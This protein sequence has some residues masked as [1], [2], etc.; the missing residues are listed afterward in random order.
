[1]TAPQVAA[2]RPWVTRTLLGVNVL[3]FV[4]M[5]V[6]G[7]SFE[8]AEQ[9]VRW[10]ADFGPLTLHGEWWRLATAMFLHFGFLHLAFNMWAL[11]QVGSVAERLFGP[12]AFLALYV[13]SGLGGSVM[14]VWWHPLVVGGGASGAIFG[15]A[16]GLIAA[17]LL[18][19]ASDGV[20]ALERVLPSLI[21][22]VLYNLLFG[23]RTPGID[24][25]AHM[26]GLLVG[27]LFGAVLAQW[28]GISRAWVTLDFALALT[29]GA[30]AAARVR[31]PV[32]VRPTAEA[33]A[34][35]VAKLPDVGAEA[36]RLEVLVARYPDSTALYVA[37]GTAYA[38]LNRPA[39]AL[40]ILEQAR[41]RRPDD[42][43]VLAT[44]GT[45]YLSMHRVD[46]AITTFG[47]AV[48]A[49]S[50]NRDARY[51]LAY[52]C[53][54]RGVLADA[55]PDRARADLERVLRLTRDSALVQEAR[56]QLRKLPPRVNQGGP[57]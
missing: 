15:V 47:R 13:L 12:R 5:A 45:V 20:H 27:A 51:N 55:A 18:R 54:V 6:I 35:Y 17:L 37:L 43:Q 30:Y 2:P 14:S 46:D 28:P 3:V 1:M 40:A 21:A 34:P 24:N 31:A 42:G 19:R 26:G 10:G 38:E 39:D 22:F 52:A 16:G 25:A 48:H 7:T 57:R 53:L 41:A 8:D 9:M 11:L 4:I 49:D 33:R 44:L 56:D 29:A 36:E 50:A 32:D 23:L